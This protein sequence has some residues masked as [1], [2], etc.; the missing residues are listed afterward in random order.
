MLL[1]HAYLLLHVGK[2][3]LKPLFDSMSSARRR[4][5]LRASSFDKQ[6]ETRDRIRAS[7]ALAVKRPNLPGSR[8]GTSLQTHT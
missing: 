5:T 6:V 4:L 8:K 7:V 2:L 3:I 1:I